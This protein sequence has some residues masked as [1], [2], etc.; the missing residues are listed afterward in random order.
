LLGCVG[1]VISRT[2]E[3]GSLEVR[4][5]PSEGY[6]K[7]DLDPFLRCVPGMVAHPPRYPG[8]RFIEQGSLIRNASPPRTMLG[9]Y[10]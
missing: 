6:D 7:L 1:G 5:I 8:V 9:P 3:E 4:R 10:A 2:R